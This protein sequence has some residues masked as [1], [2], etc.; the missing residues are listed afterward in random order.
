M[1][2]KPLKEIGN[3]EGFIRREN[4]MLV[5]MRTRIGNDDKDKDC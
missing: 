2:N 5:K 1:G 4:E 3:V